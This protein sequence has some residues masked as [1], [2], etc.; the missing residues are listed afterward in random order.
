M[1]ISLQVVEALV[2]KPVL[3][4][5]WNGITPRRL[6]QF[7]GS[8]SVHPSGT[9]M[10]VSCP[11]VE[12]KTRKSCGGVPRRTMNEDQLCES[13]SQI[14]GKVCGGHTCHHYHPS[15][16]KARRKMDS[17]SQWPKRKQSRK[18]CSRRPVARSEACVSQSHTKTK[19][20]HTRVKAAIK[21]SRRKR[22]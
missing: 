16:A 13:Q 17:V 3:T 8:S 18:T 12:G 7:A 22:R 5:P 11:K 21:D 10:S 9:G 15:I 4:S 19:T 2:W 20:S 14:E 6:P 1:P